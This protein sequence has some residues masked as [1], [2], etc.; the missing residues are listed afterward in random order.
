M[1]K[2]QEAIQSAYEEELKG[3]FSTLFTNLVVDG[4]QVAGDRFRKG[5][6]KVK[7]AREIALK[8]VQ[9]GQGK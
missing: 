4:P 3:M 2:E 1:T 5:F 9:E 8:I 6:A 7:E